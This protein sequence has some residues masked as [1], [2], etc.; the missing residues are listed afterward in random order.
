[1]ANRCESGEILGL[2][3]GNGEGGE[4]K[5]VSSNAVLSG[6]PNSEKDPAFKE[7]VIIMSLEGGGRN[8]STSASPQGGHL[9]RR[10]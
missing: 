4:I 9:Y 6:L 3:F 7:L 2:D 10:V 1:M 8:C 5:A